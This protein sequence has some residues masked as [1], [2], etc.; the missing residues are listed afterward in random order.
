[1]LSRVGN[2]AWAIRCADSGVNR[3]FI[4]PYPFSVTLLVELT[5][6]WQHW[7]QIFTRN[8]AQVGNACADIFTY[9]PIYVS[10]ILLQG[11]YLTAQDRGHQSK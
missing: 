2:T 6:S 10:C 8:I 5:T 4:P 1:M 11:K 7:L 3:V 9:P